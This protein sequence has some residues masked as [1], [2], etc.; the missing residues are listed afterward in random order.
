MIAVQKLDARAE[1]KISIILALG[2]LAIT[3]SVFWNTWPPDFS[4]SYFAGHFYAVGNYDGVYA[5]PTGFFGEDFPPL[6]RE[7]ATELGEP[8]AA[9]YPFVYPPIWAALAAPLT[10]IMG[11]YTFF[12][13]FLV[14]HLA[15]VA[16]AVFLVY[17]MVKP[18]VSLILWT[19]ASL[20]L[21]WFSVITV[22]AFIHNQFQITVAFLTILAFERMI[23]GKST[24]AGAALAVA[25]A[26]KLSPAALFL[27]FIVEK[28]RRAMMSFVCVGGAL[29]L[30]S[31]AIAGID[32]HLVFLE[33][34]KEISEI[35]AVMKV[36]YNLEAFLI[37][38]ASLMDLVWIDTVP[39]VRDQ[40]VPEPLWLTIVVRAGLVIAAIFVLR[41]T[42]HMERTD[43]IVLRFVG[44]LLVFTIC[45]PLAW[46]HHYLVPLL[47]V[48]AMIRYYSLPVTALVWLGTLLATSVTAYGLLADRSTEVH[49]QVMLSVATFGAIFLL[50]MLAPATRQTRYEQV[51]GGASLRA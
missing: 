47:M 27:I 12:N 1:W 38:I 45:A 14:M 10:Q 49:L 33:R 16:T 24:Q 17:R 50:F 43:R 44:L 29:G 9:I 18:K 19:A 23:S 11:P 48:P 2:W 5:A 40:V 13:I 46:T 32:L 51:T 41:R 7:F 36:N 15:M 8:K 28:D 25:A 20:A 35:V 26:I 37:N 21:I 4:A 30:A 39:T 22:S 34:L 6:W 42:R 3:L 31:L